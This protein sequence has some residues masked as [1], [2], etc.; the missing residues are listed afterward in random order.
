MAG[1]W[2]N[3]VWCFKTLKQRWIYRDD[4][5][6]AEGVA[7]HCCWRE[8]WYRLCPTHQ[9]GDQCMW[10]LHLNCHGCGKNLSLLSPL[11]YFFLRMIEISPELLLW[12]ILWPCGCLIWLQLLSTCRK[13]KLMP[14]SHGQ[15]ILRGSPV[16]FLTVLTSWYI[17]TG[18]SKQI[19]FNLSKQ[20]NSSFALS[21]PL[22]PERNTQCSKCVELWQL[23]VQDLFAWSQNL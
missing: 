5:W 2:G 1:P 20:E 17:Y 10:S 18:L 23:W 16:G 8:R 21:L 14:K 3:R 11:L 13:L 22:I 15:L 9:K 6:A 19:F 12:Y 4:I 7:L